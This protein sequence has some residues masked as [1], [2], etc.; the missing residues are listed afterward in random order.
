M[1]AC[2]GA[3]TIATAEAVNCAPSMGDGMGAQ[4]VIWRAFAVA[5]EV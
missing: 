4:H 5:S 2:D 1:R 3:L